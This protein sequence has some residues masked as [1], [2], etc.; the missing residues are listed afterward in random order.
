MALAAPGAELAVARAGGGYAVARGTSF[1][2]PVVAGLLAESHRTPDP[3]SA[4]QALR[5]VTELALDLGEPG[6]DPVYGAGLVG[7][8]SRVA[9]SAV[10]ARTR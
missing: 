8:R 6:R 10:Q 2:A 3:A 7:E 5:R 9:P 4:V 1:A